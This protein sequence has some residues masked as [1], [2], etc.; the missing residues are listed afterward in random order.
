VTI[1]P[2]TLLGNYEIVSAIGA[3]G[4]GQVYRARDT[5]LD[6]TVA[7]KV[8]PEG[9]A[10][11]PQL[12]SR[13]EREAKVISSL[14]HPNICT[15]HDIGSQDGI[16]F[17]V[18]EH[19]EGETLSDRIARGPMPLAEVYRYA[20]EIAE[21]L[22]RAHRVGIVHRDLK[23]ANV[24]ITRNGAKLLDFGL[25]KLARP[26]STDATAVLGTGT[27]KRDDLT[28]EGTVLGTY[29]YMSP[30]QLE[31][32]DADARSDLFA[33]GAVLY[34]MLTAK[35]AFSG[36]TRASVIAAILAGE[37][38][39]IA[40]LRPVTPEGLNQL[41]NVCLRKDPDE[42]WQAAHDVK[43]ELERLRGAGETVVA[44]KSRAASWLPWI[45]AAAL[46]IVSILALSGRVGKREQ[47]SRPAPIVS[48]ITAPGYI[49]NATD[50]PAVISADGKRIVAR[51]ARAGA[52]AGNEI[53]VVRRL[54]SA[55]VIPLSGTEGGFDP[56][57]SSD[58]Q[59]IAFFNKSKL[60]RMPAGGGPI[61]IVCESGADPRGGTWA[62]DTILF[63]PGPNHALKR[64]KASG[65]TP[66]EM[67]KLDLAHGEVGRLR[68]SFL[69]DGRHYFFSSPNTQQER[70]GVWLG[71][72]EDP[73]FQQKVL[74]I[75]TTVVF[76][77]P[78]HLLYAYGSDLYAQAFDARTL[79]KS[80]DPVSIL[81]NI[82]YSQ[83]FG[84]GAYSASANGT[85]VVQT[86]RGESRSSIV[87]IGP[88]GN[89]TQTGMVGANI[90][91]VP[92]GGRLAVQIDD[93]GGAPDIWIL[94]LV[95][96][97]RVRVTSSSAPDIGPV[98]SADGTRIAYVRIEAGYYSV[99][100]NNVAGSESDEELLRS[101]TSL[102]VT[103]WSPDGR[104]LIA[105]VFN[106]LSS[107]ICIIDLRGDRKLVPLVAGKF[108]ENSPR[109]SPDGRLL[110]Y[111]ANDSGVSDIYVQPFPLTGQRWV[112]TPNAGTSGRWSASGKEIYYVTADRRVAVV[113][114]DTANGFTV[115]PP[116]F[117]SGSGSGDISEPDATGTIYASV[118][119]GTGESLTL[120]TDW[121]RALL[122][123]NAATRPD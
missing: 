98:W 101:Q 19:L 28:S 47:T 43:I 63:A 12:R 99:R 27:H 23:P 70:S 39:P 17:L 120:V 45:A 62:G 7:I 78:G 97:S 24:M 110:V 25:A 65:G 66:T 56:F 59:Q 48:A 95:R 5:R 22:S 67:G 96:G 1:A 81:K 30:E 2:G 33:F 42:R 60:M 51:A 71:D 37:P 104:Y 109:F 6:R 55:D 32:L 52:Q 14:S 41:V 94:D 90:D 11:N 20:I 10:S 61:A 88:D 112:V 100:I 121:Q 40:T 68:P 105:E 79:K 117:L 74:D 75:W 9:F 106:D 15:L 92:D 111:Q 4:M 103:D 13:F 77:P 80:G 122:P 85:L 123:A 54:D 91:L 76:A 26:G 38:P 118:Q 18:L 114:V 50:G 16:D 113:P 87:A 49:F 29:P 93:P 57:W 102:E 58:G 83:Q 36:K 89:V 108:V 107:D 115:G 86:W 69:P 82:E 119:R 31:G 3:G 44:K 35:R 72:L 8:L 116:K 46:A 73:S 64:V 21:A 84:S 53:L 34:E